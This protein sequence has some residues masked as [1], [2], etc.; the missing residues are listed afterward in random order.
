MFILRKGVDVGSYTNLK[1]YFK[2]VGK[3]GVDKK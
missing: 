1:C 2:D 3:D